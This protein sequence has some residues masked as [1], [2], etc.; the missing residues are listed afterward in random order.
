MGEEVKEPS[1]Q[2]IGRTIHMY[3][4][5]TKNCDGSSFGKKE[6]ESGDKTLKE[7]GSVDD[8]NKA[9]SGW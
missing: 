4:K 9:D 2:V 6:S 1:G 7:R 3:V 8:D 5:F